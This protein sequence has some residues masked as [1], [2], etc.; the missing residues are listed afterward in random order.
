MSEMPPLMPGAPVPTRRWK[1]RCGIFTILLAGATIFV[2]RVSLFM[3]PRFESLFQDMLGDKSKL[4]LLSQLVIQASRFMQNKV[5]IIL[6]VLLVVFILLWWRR[7]AAWI[8]VV[9]G[10]F[11]VAFVGFGVTAYPAMMLPTAQIMKSLDP[12]DGS[13]LSDEEKAELLKAIRGEGAG[14]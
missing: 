13:T 11:I 2:G 7:G 8:C 9:C 4:P 6:L 3:V 14:R 10:A 5:L 1:V 12:P